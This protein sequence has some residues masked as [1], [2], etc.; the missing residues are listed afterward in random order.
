MNLKKL[1]IAALFVILSLSPGLV[2]V[3]GQQL[4]QF[5]TN[6]IEE[7]IDAM[8]IEEK[9]YMVTGARRR[10]VI[11]VA[12][13][14]RKQKNISGAGSYTYPF[15]HLNIP[16]I[17]VSDGPAGLRIA[18]M[19]KNDRNTYYATAFPVASLIAS[20]WD[21]ILAKKVGKAIGHE[22]LE[23]G[24]DILLG[25]ALNIHRDPLGGR[26]FEYYSEDPFLTGKMTAATVKGIQ[27]Q[28]IGVALKH[29]AANNQ[30]TSRRFINTIVS[31][32]A[33]REIYLEGFRIA[34]VEADPWTV[35]SSYNKINGVYTSESEELLETI[36]RKEWGF[37]GFVMSDWYGG[38]NV[39]KQVAAGND[40][41]MPGLEPWSVK[42]D[43]AVTVGA[44]DEELLDRNI[45]RILKVIERTSTYKNY[46]YSE[47]PDLERNAQIARE[48]ATESIVLLKN[49]VATLPLSPKIQKIAAFGAYSYKLIEGGT[50]SGMVNN[51]YTVSLA[52]GLESANYELDIELKRL[53]KEY[54]RKGEPRNL[55]AD[56]LMVALPKLDS[57]LGELPLE[58]K[59]IAKKAKETDVAIVTIM[60]VF[61][62]GGDHDLKSFYLSTEE[63]DLL[64]SVSEAYRAEGKKV[65]VVL[66]IGGVIEVDSWRDSADAIL[67]AWQPGQEGGHSL[68]DLISGKANPSGKLATTFPMDYE[69]VPTFGNFPGVPVEEPKEVT[70]EEGIYVGYRYYDSF[71]IKPAYEFGFGL[72]YTDFKYSNLDLKKKELDDIISISLE[73]ENTGDVAGKEI[74]EMYISAPGK[75]LDKP[76]KELKGFTKTKVLQPGEKQKVSFTVNPRLLSSYHTDQA[77][78]V[79][80]K[81]VYK[82]K[83]GSSSIDIRSTG[84]FTVPENIVIEKTN[85]VL[86]PQRDISEFKNPSK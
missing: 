63:V 18:P 74:L 14:G 17:Y 33:L 35:M 56:S 41:L 70:Y 48:A 36:L 30:E 47:K 61:G 24:V 46:P 8:T 78:W 76:E 21:T 66:N 3:Q 25:P 2:K 7:V 9:S 27:S 13:S 58:K 10:E 67:L 55:K 73:V 75:V 71:H 4:P 28:G 77:A 29:F 42:I 40:L 81:G 43:S 38:E 23:Y 34:V 60:R 59:L 79:V 83:I 5:G 15:V 16:A 80:E 39:L 45:D 1:Y 57:I 31:E 85:R 20:S 69:Q 26:N 65:V 53:Y 32:R 54:L 49:N 52:E 51:E 64:N 86:I 11:P 22:V 6:S 44:L 50:G 68:A 82:I 72:S 19:R 12:T 84:E 62:E 37:K